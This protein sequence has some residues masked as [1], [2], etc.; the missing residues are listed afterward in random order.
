MQVGDLVRV[1]NFSHTA[2][3]HY[4]ARAGMDTYMPD[5]LDGHFLGLIVSDDNMERH[6]RVLI[7]APAWRQQTTEIYSEERMEVINA[8]R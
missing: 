8:A 2:R 6:W 4:K 1:Y 3:K 7:Q 5:D